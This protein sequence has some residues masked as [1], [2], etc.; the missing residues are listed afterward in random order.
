[1][2]TARALAGSLLLSTGVPMIT[3]GD[4]L[5]RTQ[6]GNNNPYCQDNELSWYDWRMTPEKERQLEFFARMIELR[7]EHPIFHRR[8]FFQGRP[9]RGSGVKDIIWLR[10]DGGEMTDTEWRSHARCLGVYF[11][12]EG[13]T[14]IDT[15]GRPLTDAS[16]LVLFSAEDLE[17]PFLLPQYVPESRWLLVMDTAYEHGLARGH[18]VDAGETYPLHPRSIVLLQEQYGA[19]G[20]R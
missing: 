5:W 6:R 18:A 8:H 17:I 16:F 7:C 10:P 3:A 4:E 11:S 9:I 20:Y 13:L 15:Q 14:E 19:N 12:R 1:L 2:R